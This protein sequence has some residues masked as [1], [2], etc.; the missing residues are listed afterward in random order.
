[1]TVGV[2]IAKS[3]NCFLYRITK[4]GFWG[5]FWLCN[6]VQTK[7][8]AGHCSQEVNNQVAF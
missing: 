7:I 6:C 1:M 3:I 5:K 8:T 4:T 2:K